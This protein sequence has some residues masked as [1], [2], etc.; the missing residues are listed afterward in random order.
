MK[1]SIVAQRPRQQRHVFEVADLDGRK[2]AV[3]G[4]R[5][6]RKPQVVAL[7][8]RL[9]SDMVRQAADQ[10]ALEADA[11]VAGLSDFGRG[12]LTRVADG[13]VNRSTQAQAVKDS[14]QAIVDQLDDE[15]AE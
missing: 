10:V 5:I 15:P 12:L 4:D 9:D 2:V 8:A 1:G 7:I 6:L 11:A 13:L 14:L 3:S